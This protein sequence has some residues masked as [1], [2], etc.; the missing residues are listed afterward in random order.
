MT[1]TESSTATLPVFMLA[2]LVV[3]DAAT[4]LN[5]E[6]GFFP[7]LKR[8]GGEFL[9]FDDKPLTLEGENPPE[10]RVILFKFPSEQAARDWYADAEYQA[11]SEHR[12][13]GTTL[14]CLTIVH[15]LP[16]RS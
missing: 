7:I 11:I 10:G 13:A 14:K 16:P 15:S 5:Y 6:K 8:Y 4:Y 9:T 1:N 3:R 12:R 2:N